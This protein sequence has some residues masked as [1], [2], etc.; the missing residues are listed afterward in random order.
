MKICHH[1]A[2]LLQTKIYIMDTEIDIEEFAKNNTPV[3]KGKRY[4]IRVDREKYVTN[5]ECLTGMEILL[6]AGK[7]PYTKFQLNQKIKGNVKKVGYDEKVDF[8]TPGIERFMTLPL[9]QTEG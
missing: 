6:L 4:K 3:P 9:D 7:T 5:E 1:L 2:Y 8:T